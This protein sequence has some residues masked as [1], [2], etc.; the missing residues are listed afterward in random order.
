MGA[1]VRG[2][3]VLLGRTVYILY[4][5]MTL[6]LLNDI[7]ELKEKLRLAF[8]ENVETAKDNPL[9]SI[10]VPTWNDAE[11]LSSLLL[12]IKNQSFK[13]IEVI[14]ADCQS[15]DGTRELAKSYGAN[16]LTVTKRGI[17]Y[18]SHMAVLRSKGD[19]IIRTDADCFFPTWLI[20]CVVNLFA[21]LKNVMLIHG[22]HLYY[23]A[24][25]FTNLLAHL[26]D[27]HWR[28]T[29]NASGIFIAFRRSAYFNVGG[30]NNSIQY[31]EDWNFSQR[32]YKNSGKNSIYYDP[33]NLITL[34]SARN[35][36]L[37]G[38]IRYLLE[39]KTFSESKPRTT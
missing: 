24:G 28:R 39:K 17:G 30:F 16:V 13:N 14:V 27:K 19:I 7:S 1:R 4:L 25:F 34:T 6:R 8:S 9:V 12:S 37:K 31:G 3:G 21:D 26:Y 36:K 2:L 5:I 33:L 11:P 15:T 32:V 35:I 22:G 38:F 29:G 18:Q 20:S 10:I 23:D